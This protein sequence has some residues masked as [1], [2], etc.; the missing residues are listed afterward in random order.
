MLSTR[1]IVH[2][3]HKWT[4]EV[5]RISDV[6][7]NEGGLGKEQDGR[8]SRIRG[9]KEARRSGHA[10]AMGQLLVGAGWQS[11]VQPATRARSSFGHAL[12]RSDGMAAIRGRP[13]GYEPVE[14]RPAG[15]SQ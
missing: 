8:T 13:V 12:V 2:A 15:H 9:E 7:E 1:E 3:L 4:T 11:E 6:W 5:G 14:H 10:R